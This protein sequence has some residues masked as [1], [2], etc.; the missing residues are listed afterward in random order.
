M[1]E[2]SKSNLN[3]VLITVIAIMV[4]LVSYIYIS[5]AAENTDFKKTETKALNELVNQMI[6]LKVSNFNQHKAI[7]LSVE[8]YK[9]YSETILEKQIEP[10]SKWR[11]E[12]EP[13]LSKVEKELQKN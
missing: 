6:E 2:K 4:S 8:S 10:N 5:D 11:I 13:R 9:I 7:I 12:G 1:N 3:S